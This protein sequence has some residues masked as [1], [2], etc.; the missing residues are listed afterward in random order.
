MK[1]LLFV[2]RDGTILIE[3]EDKQIDSLEKLAFVEGAIPALKTLSEAGWVLVLVS[4]QDGLGT[5]SFPTDDFRKPQEMMLQILASAG[6]RFQDV[7]ICPHFADAECLCR[8][9]RT[10]LLRSIIQEGFDWEKSAV[11]GDRDTDLDL[12]EALGTK[13][14]KLSEKTSWRDILEDLLFKPRQAT[15][16]RK[17]RET[18]VRVS[19]NLDSFKPPRIHTGSPFFDH[20]LEQVGYHAGLALDIQVAG[21]WPVDDHHSVED[22]AI[23]LGEC[24][25]KALGD[26]HG[27][28]RYGFVLPMDESL[29]EV[30]LDLSGRA[31]CHFEAEFTR[32][33]VSGLATEMIPH[34]FRS[35]SEG[36]RATLHI[37]I[38]GTNNHHLVESGFKGFGRCLAQ[39]ISVRG[40]AIPSSKGAL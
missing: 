6:I 25:R 39:A 10:G 26:K 40:G 36:L 8:K 29:A 13:G 28:G 3:P 38:R 34:F 4:N 19:V 35:L 33:R 32:E 20:M 16:G 23:T 22:T 11:I 12:A 24:L 21:D 27:I 14:Y 7:L 18:D 1:K 37:R 15:I 17:T 9:P 30:S 2:D 31:F 5:D